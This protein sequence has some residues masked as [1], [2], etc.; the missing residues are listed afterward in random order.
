MRIEDSAS[1]VLEVRHTEADTLE[2]FGL[3]V[4]AFDIAV[5]PREIQCVHN[6]GE[7]VVTSLSAGLEFGKVHNLH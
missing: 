6:F 3:V 4:A 2:D 5:C 7:P 1:E